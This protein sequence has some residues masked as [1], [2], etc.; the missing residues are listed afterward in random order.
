MV[1]AIPNYRI[2]K[3]HNYCRTNIWKF[4]ERPAPSASSNQQ[5]FQQD[6]IGMGDVAM[7]QVILQ[8]GWTDMFEIQDVQM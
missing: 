4:T 2:R 8:N 3:Y 1:W 6:T 7:A 5:T